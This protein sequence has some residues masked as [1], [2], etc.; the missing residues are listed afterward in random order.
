MGFGIVLTVFF[1]IA[2]LTAS[3][4]ALDYA[5]ARK[6]IEDIGIVLSRNCI[7]M[8]QNDIP[9]ECPTYEEIMALH[10]DTSNHKVS[11]DFEFINGMLQRGKAPYN[12][13][14]GWYE[15][16][17]KRIW[18]DP[19]GDIRDKIMIITIENNL[20]DYLIKGKSYHVTNQT[21]TMGHE[22]YVDAECYNASIS[23]DN[24]VFLLGDTIR[25]MDNRCN[26]EYTTFDHIKKVTLEKTFQDITTSYKYKLEKW[27]EES[28]KSCKEL[29]FQY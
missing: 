13:H 7:T 11:G 24:W 18:I 21:I 25:Y 17:E 28:K 23:A 27:I 8:I 5:E 4:Y 19:P 9:T 10:P 16:E 15:F 1:S 29:C 22:R 12:D 14:I 6:N 2:V 3:T 26:E 20:G